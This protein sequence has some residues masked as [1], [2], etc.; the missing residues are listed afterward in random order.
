MTWLICNYAMF[1]GSEGI[2]VYDACID[3]EG[4]K[5]TVLD[6]KET[7]VVNDTKVAENVGDGPHKFSEKEEKEI[8]VQDAALELENRV[9]GL[10]KIAES[11]IEVLDL[12]MK[13]ESMMEGLKEMVKEGEKGVDESEMEES[14]M[15]EDAVVDEEAQDEE[16]D[17]EEDMVDYYNQSEMLTDEERGKSEERESV[18][19]QM[20]EIS[21][22]IAGDSRKSGD[23]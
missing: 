2:K 9:E 13:L 14:G 16:S 8:N 10:K 19:R 4:L 5:V 18:E 3:M 22:E 20:G 17:Q 6:E 21:G 15:E 1:Q 11:E 12:A 7:E 23:S